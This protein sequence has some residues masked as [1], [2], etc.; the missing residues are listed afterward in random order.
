MIIDINTSLGRWPFQRFDVNSAQALA[1]RL[2]NVGIAKALVSSIDA[3]LYPDPAPCDDDLLKAVQGE[4]LFIPVPTVNPVLTHWRAMLA[5]QGL[6][7]VRIVP[8][9]H[10]YSLADPAVAPFME[11]LAVMKM[12]LLIQMRV[13]DERNQYPL[14]KVPGV[15]WKDVVRLADAFPSVSIVCLCAYRGEAVELV[16]QTKNV[17]VDISFISMFRTLPTLLQQIAPDRILFGSHTPFF[18]TVSAVMKLEAARQM[19]KDYRAVA[20]SNAMQLFGIDLSKIP[21]VHQG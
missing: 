16:R 8:N 13:D 2:R 11:T 14:M 7:A 1:K 12:P 9:Y 20:C 3:V 4:P 15:A 10:N 5:A 18:Y 19:E 6:K 21:E 17:R